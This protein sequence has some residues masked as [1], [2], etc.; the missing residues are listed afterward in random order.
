MGK[1]AGPAPR[2]GCNQVPA[3]CPPPPQGHSVR[4]ETLRPSSPPRV[5][6]RQLRD[7]AAAPN[8][9][10][11]CIYAKEP[12]PRGVWAILGGLV[13]PVAA[14]LGGRSSRGQQDIWGQNLQL[15]NVAEVMGP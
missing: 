8:R 7:P 12:M 15:P 14:M 9:T 4:A 3:R 6:L 1:P 13:E 5:R 11:P 2:L 10:V